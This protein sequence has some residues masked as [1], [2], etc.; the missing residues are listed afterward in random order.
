MLRPQWLALIAVGLWASLIPQV[1]YISASSGDPSDQIL[2]AWP[3]WG[4]QQDLGSLSGSVGTFYVWTSAEPRGGHVTIQASLVDAS[5]RAVLRQTSLNAAPD[6][7]TVMRTLDFPEYT[8]PNG[9]RL[10]LQLQVAEFEHNYALYR[11]SSPTPDL[12]SVAVNGVSNVGSGP[13][14]F[15]HEIKGS[16]MR[17]AILGDQSARIRLALA[18]AASALAILAHPRIARRLRCPIPGIPRSLRHSIDGVG[19][20]HISSP[21]AADATVQ[22]KIHRVLQ[23]PW[24]PWLAAVAP[25]LHFLASNTLHFGVIEAVGPLVVVLSLVTGSMVVLSLALRDS[26][27]AGVVTTIT[28]LVFFGYGH[29]AAALDDRVDERFLF[30]GVIVL[31]ASAIVGTMKVATLPRRTTQL[32]NFASVILLVFPVI[33]LSADKLVSLVRASPT[34]TTSGDLVSHVLPAGIPDVTG[35]RP[36]VYYIILDEYTRSDALGEFDN[37]DFLRELES[38]GFY[39][40]SEATSNYKKSIR[41]IP[42][43]LNMTYLDDLGPRSPDSDAESVEVGQHNA[44]AAI[45]KTLGYTYIHLQSGH[46]VTDSAPLADQLV[47]FTLSG[48]EVIRDADVALHRDTENET[49]SWRFACELAQTTLL[50]PA[51]RQCLT[52]EDDAPLVWWSPIRALRMFEFLTEP[53]ES[54]SPKFV[55]GHI[56]KPHYPAT[57][58]RYGNMIVGT[59]IHDEFDDRHDPSVPSAYIGQLIFVNSLVLEMVDSILENSQSDPIIVLAGDHGRHRDSHTRYSVLAAFYLPDGGTAAVYPSISSVNHFRAILKYYFGLKLD[60]L[61]DRPG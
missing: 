5:T 38:R 24:Y 25:V 43:I 37:S 17:T 12:H 14:A 4:V 33:S 45:L 61:E 60:L 3:G 40:A 36:D 7:I 44:V 26:H 58:D 27:L 34:E 15:A 42:S 41:A 6:S 54:E 16:G 29:I 56:L 32:L 20:F 21:T 35:H 10:L 31:A 51:V 18:S 1:T 47:R 19:G 23:R 50:W 8:V 57:F 46:A 2:V 49:V 28:L 22:S 52:P 9:Q 39:V 48:T 13:L 53:I 59:S 11:L 55:L 30:G